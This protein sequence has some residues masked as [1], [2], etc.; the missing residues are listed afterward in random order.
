MALPKLLQKL[1]ADEGKGPKLNPSIIPTKINGQVPDE[2]GEFNLQLSDPD[3]ATRPEILT[4]VKKVT[5]SSE[6]TFEPDESLPSVGHNVGEEWISYTGRIP[7]GGVPYCGQEVT[8]ETYRDLWEYAQTQGLVKSEEEWQRIATACNGNCPFYSSGDGSTTFRMPK[9]I[10]YIRGAVAPSEAGG[11]AKEGL[12]NI[13]G[14][15]D[16]NFDRNVFNGHADGA[17]YQENGQGRRWAAN[18]S[19]TTTLGE[20]RFDASRSNPIYGTSSHVTP[21]TSV[22]LFGVYAFGEVV[23]VGELDAPLLASSIARIESSYVSLNGGTLTGDL[24]TNQHIRAT[25]KNQTFFDIGGGSSN[26][27]AGQVTLYNLNDDA[28]PGSVGLSSTDGTQVHHLRLLRDGR[29]TIDNAQIPTNTHPFVLDYARRVDI[30]SGYVTPS[31]GFVYVMSQG[32]YA[33]ATT[34]LVNGLTVGIQKTTDYMD[35]TVVAWV[36]KGQTITYQRGG[37]GGY[38]IFC[39]FVVGG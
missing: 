10:G 26:L 13:T 7:F 39:P 29:A 20:M 16:N 9:I 27:S 35:S 38:A 25:G 11:Y 14:R 5:E 2:T 4:A 24:W 36:N 1:F 15:L 8:R 6:V 32:N 21:E 30:P 34:V 18:E 37:S 23:N 19:T 22:V 31:A 33:G 3:A 28:H 17:F 12:P